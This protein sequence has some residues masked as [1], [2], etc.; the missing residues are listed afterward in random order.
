LTELNRLRAAGARERAKLRVDAA[1]R[2]GKIVPAQPEWAIAYCQANVRGFEDFV[3]RQP[4]VIAGSGGD[5]EGEPFAGRSS[6]NDRDNASVAGSRA[7]VALTRT[8]LTVC[9]RLGLRP[10]EYLK[11][12]GMRGDFLT[13]DQE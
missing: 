13:A 10:Q 12:R 6:V 7:K 4:M 11:R 8:E 3:A 9:G 1:M 5:F 2:A